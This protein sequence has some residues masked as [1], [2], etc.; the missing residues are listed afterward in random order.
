LAFYSNI[1]GHRTRFVILWEDVDE[2][3]EASHSFGSVGVLLNRSILVFTKKGRASD[4]QHGAKSMDEK[5][6]FKFQFLSIIHFKP[7]L[8]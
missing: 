6:R 4:A 7:A 5:G 8:R 2:I 3:K 1:F